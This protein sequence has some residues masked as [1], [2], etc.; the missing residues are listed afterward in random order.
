MRKKLAWCAIVVSLIGINSLAFYAQDRKL[1][2]GAGRPSAF[3]PSDV[4]GLKLWLKADAITGLNN[5][6]P[7][8]TWS[9]QSGQ[10][11]DVTQA[12]SV[13]RPLYKTAISNGLP[14][15]RFDGSND[16]LSSSTFTTIS[17]AFTIFLV[18]KIRAD[19]YVFD[20][21]GNGVN[22][23]GYVSG[24]HYL[25]FRAGADLPYIDA[26]PVGFA[27]FTML[28]NGNSS[29]LRKNGTQQYAGDG[30]SNSISQLFLGAAFNSTAASDCDIAEFL[31]YDSDVTA[32][33]SAIE[34]HLTT[35]WGL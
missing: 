23:T 7:V 15:V 5:D 20:S 27:V 35:K 32:S 21:D 24:S 29:V 13:K 1:L 8:T 11:N 10:G 6:D 2:L 16:V 14:V 17:Q 3:S 4:A 25:K 18:V 26:L 31:L 30:G 34:S 22:F 9:D 33:F 19:Q 12:D 28:A